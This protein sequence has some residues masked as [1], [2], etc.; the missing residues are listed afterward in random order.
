MIAQLIA[1]LIL[2]ESNSDAGAIGD[3]GR[4]LGCL[5]IHACVIEDVNRHYNRSF[6]HDDALD[7]DKAILICELYLRMYAP[8][9]ATLEQLARIWN[10][11]PKGYKKKSTKAYWAKVR[12]YLY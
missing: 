1:A 5:Q 3:G 12:R 8:P 7:M 4:A 10:G 9:G 6:K 11:G 2:V